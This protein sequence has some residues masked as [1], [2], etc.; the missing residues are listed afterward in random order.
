M[1]AKQEAE[2]G[3][4]ICGLSSRHMAGLFLEYRKQ[5]EAGVRGTAVGVGG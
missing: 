1:K 4:Q 5:G 2:D 3:I